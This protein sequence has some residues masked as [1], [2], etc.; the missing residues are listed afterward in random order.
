MNN[1]KRIYDN[2][3][4]FSFVMHGLYSLERIKR[5]LVHGLLHLNG[6]DHGEEHIS[7]DSAPQCKMLKKQEKLLVKLKDE[8]IIK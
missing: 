5:L 7:K 3:Q 2:E 6:Y 1:H 4:Q 8:I